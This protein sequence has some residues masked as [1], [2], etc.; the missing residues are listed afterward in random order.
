MLK[1]GTAS[2]GMFPKIEAS[3][4]ALSATPITRIING[5]MSHA[6]LNELKNG[7]GGTSIV[8]K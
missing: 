5:K 6:L 1:L 3:I 8:P 2:G 7:I 4:K